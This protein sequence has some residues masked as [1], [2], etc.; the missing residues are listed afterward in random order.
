MLFIEFPEIFIFPYRSSYEIKVPKSV[1]A[2]KQLFP[3]PRI[4]TWKTCLY[5]TLLVLPVLIIMNFYGLYSNRFYLLKIDNYIFPVVTILHFIYLYVINFKVKEEE[6][7][8]PQMRNVEYGM[9]AVLLIYV[10]KCLDTLY[11]LFSYDDYDAHIIPG[12]FLPVGVSILLFQLFLVLLTGLA[13]YYRK[14]LVGSYNFDQINENFDS[15]P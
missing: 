8:D 1:K 6:F 12:T 14:A 11:I 13:F 15:W 4:F 10:F 9:Y 5:A 7:A 3:L 2:I